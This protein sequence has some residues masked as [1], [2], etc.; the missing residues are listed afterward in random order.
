MEGKEK[1]KEKKRCIRYFGQIYWQ[2]IMT[3]PS[4]HTTITFA[5]SFQFL[6]RK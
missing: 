5:A 2:Q 3:L 6:Y 4:V 1:E